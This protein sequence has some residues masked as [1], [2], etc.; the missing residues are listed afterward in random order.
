MDTAADMIHCFSPCR[1]SSADV[2]EKAIFTLVKCIYLVWKALDT[3]ADAD[4]AWH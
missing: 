1:Q 4:A 3:D 2:S